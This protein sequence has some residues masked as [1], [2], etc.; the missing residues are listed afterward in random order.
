L[1][2]DTADTLEG[3]IVKRM[4]GKAALFALTAVIFFAS[5]VYGQWDFFE[6]RYKYKLEEVLD[7]DRFV[8][9][10]GYWEGHKGEKL[11]GYVLLSKEWTAKLVGYS[12]KHMETL[13]GVDTKGIITGIKLLYHSEPI[14]LIGLKEKNYLKFLEQFTGKDIHQE[15]TLGKGVSMDAVTGA[16]VT[17]VVQNAIILRSARKVAL[18]A[19]IIEAQTSKRQ[20]I[21][22][23]LESLA[24]S[25]LLS[26]EA[27]K[28]LKVT[29][30]DLEEP[31]DNVYLDLYFGVATVPTIGSSVLGEKLFRQTTQR[32]VP[33][34][35]AIFIF[36]RGEGSFK[37]SGFAR[38]GVFDRFNVRQ[39]E[40]T[41][42]FKDNDYH[43]LT[44]IRAEGA[45][46]IREGGL[47]VIRDATFDPTSPYTFNLVLPHRKGGTKEFKSFS[48]PGGIPERFLEKN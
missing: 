37:G 32:L 46:E 14:V 41:I 21:S 18:A 24:W 36:S 48:A 47:F 23:R 12:G 38:G 29:A 40:N 28:N 15:F 9:R 17:A 22:D 2:R 19:G 5:T 25:E 6:H 30:K 44:D 35:T 7:A 16:T 1:G 39:G 27:L 11:A 31:G 45:P 3:G 43:I 20:K 8:E 13:I 4:R 26:S 34:E 10:D 42:L 33:G